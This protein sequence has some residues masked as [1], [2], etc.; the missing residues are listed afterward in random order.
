MSEIPDRVRSVMSAVQNLHV[1]AT[2]D[3][4]G[5]PHMRWMGALVEDPKQPWTF[6]LACGKGSR[7]MQQL[8]ANPHAE[9]LFTKQDTWEVA[10]LDGIGESVDTPE[11]RQLLWEACPA[12]RQYYSGVD[13]PGMGIIKFTTR[14]M[15]LLSMQEGHEPYCFDLET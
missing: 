13:D 4:D 10:T 3:V 14:C 2:V 7:K 5:R 12:M 8:A 1:L 15:E 11:I 6:Y 9:L